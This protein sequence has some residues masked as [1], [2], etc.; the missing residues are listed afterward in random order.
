MLIKRG[1]VSHPKVDATTD[2][3]HQL[4]LA[5]VNSLTDGVVAVDANLNILMANGAALALL[6]KNELKGRPIADVLVLIDRTGNQI[7][8]TKLIP[9]SPTGYSSRAFRIK[10]NDASSLN[11]YLS[12]AP[13]K[14]SYG[15]D[16]GGGFVMIMRD[17]SAE[18]MVEDERDDFINVAGHELKTP[19]T[20]AEGSISNA[21]VMAQ[22]SEASD[23]LVQSLKT[24]HDQILFLSSMINDLAVLSRADRGKKA[25]Y[26]EEFKIE[27]LFQEL[28]DAYKPQAQA[29]NLTLSFERSED[30]ERLSSS[31]LY[32][33]E[34]LQ[35]LITNS[36]KYTVTGGVHVSATV[37]PG[38]IQFRVT[39]T[40]IG[41]NHSDQSKM[42][43]KFFRSTDERVK[44]QHGTGLGL[45][46]TAKLADLLGAKIEVKSDINTGST[47]LVTCPNLNAPQKPEAAPNS[48]PS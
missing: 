9:S 25:V 33:N 43:E 22:R 3:D 36:I 24:A 37:L 41:I 11:L 44:S 26:I 16:A 39:D 12:L 14:L 23:T 5:L 18:K 20:I 40:G 34:I 30:A 15:Q 7:D 19:V 2:M 47:F 4:L 6:D 46:V 13:V 35:N 17:I 42:F 28:N 32:V 21:L 45:Y 8:L 31:R 27:D 1:G 38:G 29:K 10:F 48:A